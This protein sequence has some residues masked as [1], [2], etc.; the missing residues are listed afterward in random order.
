[1]SRYDAALSAAPTI[2]VTLFDSRL[3]GGVDKRLSQLGA[4]FSIFGMPAA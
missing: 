4:R 1:L 2:R 3:E